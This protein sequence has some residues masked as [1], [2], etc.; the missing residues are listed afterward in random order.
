LAGRDWRA[1][2]DAYDDPAAPL[3]QRLAVVR[4]RLADALDEAP[5][6]PL[7]VI[8]MCAGQGRDLIPVLAAHPR[9]REVTARLVELDPGIAVSARRSAAAAGLPGAEVVTGDA[10]RCGAYEG[11]VPAQIVLACG[12]F[13]NIGDAGV[14]NTIGC[15]PRLCAEGATV[16]WTRGRSG[17]AK[18]PQIC[19]WFGEQGFGLR[20]LSAP[21]PSFCVGV[22]RFRGGLP[23]VVPAR[24]HGGRPGPL[25]P[26]ARMFT[27][28]R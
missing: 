5:P 16:V 2:H 9:G 24:R 23:G 18:V 25:D 17:P 6:G 7:R 8:S 10:G 14:E 22:H 12:V 4:A 13:G 11:A 21:G 1:W 20:W 28:Q 26:G 15:L 27:F 3:A 19:R